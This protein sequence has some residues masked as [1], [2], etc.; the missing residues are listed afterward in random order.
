MMEKIMTRISIFF[1]FFSLFWAPIQ[2]SS[3]SHFDVWPQESD[4]QRQRGA[5]R[6]AMCLWDDLQVSGLWL[7]TEL[8][9]MLVDRPL[10][11]G[12]AWFNTTSWRGLLWT[13]IKCVCNLN[14]F[15]T[16]Y[17][18]FLQRIW[19]KKTISIYQA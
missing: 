2:P 16:R 3:K 18:T 17:F 6:Q 11:F 4:R 5:V 8:P 13:A 19:K 9:E 1:I 12:L 7:W 10:S 15:S 14:I